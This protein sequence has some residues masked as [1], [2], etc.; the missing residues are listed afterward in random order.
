MTR[1][2]YLALFLPFLATDRLV[3]SGPPDSAARD[4][5]P[6]VVVERQ[7]G[8][9]RL[10]ACDPEAMALGLT[11]GVT[12]ADARARVPDLAVADAD[13]VADLLWLERIADACDRFT[14]RVAIE[15]PD[16]LVLDITG[17][18]HLFGGEYGLLE[19]VEARMRRWTGHLRHALADTPEGARAL[20]RFQTAPAAS[21]AAALR[22][23]PVAALEL[24]GETEAALRGAGLKTIDDLVS[25]PTGPLA[26]RFGADLPDLLARILGKS[27]KPIAP[28][29]TA[30]AWQFERRFAEPIARAD[31]ALT[32]IGE[33]AAEAGQAMEARRQGG[34]RFT[35]RLFRSDGHVVDLAIDCGQPLRDPA[36]IM[37][38]F[39]ER[40]GALSDPIDPGFGFDMI[41]LSVPRAEPLDYAQLE[42]EGGAVH[43]EDVS[44]LIDRLS[45]RAGSGRIRRFVPRDSHIPEQAVL[46]LPATASDRQDWPAPPSGEPPCR[47]IHL[48]DPP[49]RVEVIAELPDGPPRSFRWQRT[50]HEVTRYEGPERI[51]AEWWHRAPGDPG[52]T[53]DYY[54]V[55]DM[56][57]RRLWLFRHG[58]NDERPAPLWY[59]HGLFA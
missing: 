42:L 39:T 19:A 27:G 34:R 25:R 46:A 4:S 11:P 12:L 14:P 55:E 30:P 45:V 13:P 44:A 54:R 47:P 9:I 40:I 41:R 37:R 58:L 8:A 29:H 16:G 28:R 52:L 26:A 59:V 22:R 33:L 49:Q 51:A 18:A 7:R 56:R 15:P 3:R 57:G 24:E 2:R 10:A 31:A 21:E 32:V 1:R 36:R 35:A 38:L 53:R 20:A 5:A 6:R 17:C 23:L 50:L 43:A 48:F